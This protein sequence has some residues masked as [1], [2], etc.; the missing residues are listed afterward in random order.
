MIDLDFLGVDNILVLRGDA[1]KS[2]GRFIPDEG[3]HAYA[4]ELLGQVMELNQGKYIHEE[5]TRNPTS[6]CV[7]VAGYPEKH[8][9]APSLKSDLKYLKMKVDQGAEY[10]VTQMFL[11]IKNTFNLWINVEKRVFMCLSSRV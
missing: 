2:E 1:I 3:G 7:G 5:V 11:T 10:V 6:F 9:E 4:N 8:F